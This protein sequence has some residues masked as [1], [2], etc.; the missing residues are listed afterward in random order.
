MTRIG[1]S[2]VL[3]L[4]FTLVLAGAVLAAE[5]PSRIEIRASAGERRVDV[6]IDARPFTS[7]IW[8][9]RLA[10]PVLFPILTAQGTPVTR[11][12]PLAPRPGERVDHPHHVGLWFNH[13]AVNGVDFWNNSEALTPAERAK[14]GTVRH[15]A[16][17]QAR[18]GA[19]HGELD[20][21]LQWLMPDG[22]V[23][24]E[25]ETRYRFRA[26]KGARVIEHVTTLTATKTKVVFSDNKEGLFG[27]RVARALEQPADKPEL[28]TD[29][30]GRPTAV[31]VL[32]NAGVSG[33]YTSSEGLKG[34]AVW[35]TRGRWV[36]L[37]GRVDG[38]DVTLVMLDHPK[39]PDHP[40]HWHARG[41]GLFA[42][43]NL[44]VRVFSNGKEQLD[45]ALEPGASVTFRHALAILP[46]PFSAA[47][48][49]AA[50]KE[51]VAGSGR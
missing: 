24:L 17:K 37:S 31:P 18:S 7:Y 16:V 40:T 9:D 12:F 42:A 13:G 27:L 10:K 33:L 39:N 26:A 20:V 44:G 36:A 38:E 21:S 5:E 25:D 19:G 6:L 1:D 30:S 3:G 51:F 23:A 15:V 49:E 29:A 41:Y 34:D 11:G 4:A 48:A 32:D 22:S 28:F 46:G 14:M 2:C 45:L 47:A 8:P 35:S 43:N 50:W